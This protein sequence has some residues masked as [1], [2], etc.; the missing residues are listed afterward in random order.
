MIKSKKDLKYFIECDK[1]ALG[2]R[3][4][5]FLQKV[6]SYFFPHRILKFEYCLRKCEYHKN[7][8]GNIY[9]LLAFGIRYFYFE[10]LSVKLGFSIPL[11]VF[12]PGLAIVHFGTIVVSAQAKVGA[13]CRL[14]PSTCIG[15]SGGSDKAPIIG[16][17]VYIGP[18][19]KIYG[20]VK[21]ASDIAFAANAAV[22]KSFN[23]NG[24]LIGGVPAAKI[25]NIDI[26]KIIKHINDDSNS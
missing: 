26:K 8:S 1:K 5:T 11:N 19:V 22:N 23:E 2:I 4:L 6:K 13:N 3:S 17:N 7:N 10:R 16:D 25:Q 20:D 12:G 9:H 24:I 18:G 14:H 15:T 21:I